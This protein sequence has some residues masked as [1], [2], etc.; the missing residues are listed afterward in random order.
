[1]AEQVAGERRLVRM[2]KASELVAEDIR[3]DIVRGELRPDD[4]LPT[5]ANLID[6]YGVSRPTLREAL[7]VLEAE[8]LIS[9]QKGARGGARVRGPQLD[10]VARYGGHL[11]QAHGGSL[12]DV[13]TAQETL[14]VGAVRLLAS[15]RPEA[16]IAVLRDSL[17]AEGEALGDLAAFSTCAV[18]FHEG[19][20]AA[21]GNQ[22][23]SLLAGILHNIVERHTMLVA[24]KQPATSKPP[25]WRTKSHEVHAQVLD[26]ITAGEVDAAESLWRRHLVASRKAMMKE[27]SITNVIDLFA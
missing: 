2:P 12:N 8:S 19:L 27:I 13:L 14:Q 15:D 9:L 21:T 4:F 6:R 20:V 24:A 16:G 7:R 23:L 1:M 18:N 26:L 11:L 5:E 17:V 3:R 10:A 22:S 25:K